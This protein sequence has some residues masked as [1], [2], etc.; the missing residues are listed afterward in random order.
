MS[1]RVEVLKDRYVD[2][3]VQMSAS[4][5]MMDIDGVEWAAAAMGTPANL[6][7][8]ASKGFDTDSFE[9]TA[10]DC[11]LAIAAT[12]DAIEAALD[13]GKKALAGGADGER[14]GGLAGAAAAERPRSFSEA[15]DAVGARAS[16]GQVKLPNVAIVSVPGDYAALEAH[17]ALSAGLHVLLFSDNVSVEE[18][19]ELKERAEGAGLLVMGPGAGTA[20]LGGTCLGFANV[21]S[22]TEAGELHL[23][24]PANG[25]AFSMNR[26][27]ETSTRVKRPAATRPRSSLTDTRKTRRRPSIAS[28]TASALTFAPTGVGARWLISTRCSTALV[29]CARRPSRAAQ[30]ACSA[31]RMMLGVASTATFDVPAAADVSHSPT[32]RSMVAAEPTCR[33]TAVR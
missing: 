32:I 1:R 29:P 9:A 3:V 12:D 19:V 4:R 10:N 16:E 20:M 14:S 27:F 17:K 8:L 7:T 23:P 22:G 28:R 18:E 13:V 24:P 21:V 2:S 26:S 6:D 31:K 5:A 30:M 15:I 25:P 11:F 33:S